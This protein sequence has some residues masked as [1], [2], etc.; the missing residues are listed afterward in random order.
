MR[1][2]LPTLSAD[3]KAWAEKPDQKAWAVGMAR[4]GAGYVWTMPDVGMAMQVYDETTFRLLTLIEH[5]YFIEA[6]ALVKATLESVGL[7]L[8]A[9]QVVMAECT[10]GRMARRADARGGKDW[11]WRWSECARTRVRG[12]SPCGAK[13]ATSIGGPTRAMPA[14]TH[15]PACAPSPRQSGR[16]RRTWI[17]SGSGSDEVARILRPRPHGRRL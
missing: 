4:Y 10:P 3:Q 5:D 16:R 1:L 8:D 12:P 17:S 11:P 14:A 2:K 9:S 13:R 6:A 15:Q 7:Q